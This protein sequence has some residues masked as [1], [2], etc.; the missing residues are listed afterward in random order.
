[1]ISN[2]QYIRS[3]DAKICTISELFN[4]SGTYRHMEKGYS[5][6]RIYCTNHVHSCRRQRA[7]QPLTTC[8]PYTKHK[9]LSVVHNRGT[10]S[11]QMWYAFFTAVNL[12]LHS[13]GSPLIYMCFANEV[14]SVCLSKTNV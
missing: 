4:L 9:H 10:P 5:N 6:S 12:L 14:R 7:I 8:L 3:S 1:M 13:R 2:I 11:S